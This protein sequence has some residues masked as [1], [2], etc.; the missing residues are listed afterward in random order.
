MAA[1]IVVGVNSYA[2]VADADA[3]FATS[4]GASAAWAALTTTQKEQALA[5]AFWQLEAQVWEGTKTGLFVVATFAVGAG[6]TGYT[7]GDILTLVGG[8][9][10][11]AKVRVLTAPGGV[12]GTVEGY[13][14]GGYTVAPSGTLT[15]TGG[16]GTSCTIA[17]T[18]QV[19][20]ASW[21]RSG[22][23]DKDGLA[24]DANSVPWQII[25]AQELLAFAMTQNP[26]L[27][28]KGTQNSNI[29][30]VKAGSV[31][32]EFFAPVVDAGRFPATI[33]ELIAQFLGGDLS[34][35]GAAA[36]EKSGFSEC[37][38]FSPKRYQLSK[39]VP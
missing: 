34:S 1:L 36:V 7:V 28:S 30:S 38:E 8:T 11:V 26:S 13:D 31:A 12:V 20:T 14:V 19:Q 2:S 15:T 10:R 27:E 17:V 33:Q 39:G 23:T 35:S 25:R 18:T 29:E 9:G 21:P 4:I 6:G 22:V 16:T 5:S 37:S 32:V 24:V 3:F